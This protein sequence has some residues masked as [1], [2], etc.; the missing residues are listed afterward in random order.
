MVPTVLEC[1]GHRSR[2]PQL[3]GVTQS[4]IEGVSFAHSFDDATAPAR[5]HTQYFEMFAHRSI[6]HD[7]WRAVCPFP[8]TSFAEAGVSF[9]QLEL[10]ENK[11]RELDATGWELYNVQ[12]DPAE[13]NNLADRER[14][15]LIEMIALWYTEAGKYNVLPLDSR[16]TMRFADE[17]PQIASERDT[18]VYYPDTQA[19]PENVAAKVLNRAHTITVDAEV[20]AGDEGVLVCHGSNVGG[21]ILFVQDGRLH[22]V[23][24]YVGAEELRVSSDQPVPPG[25]HA[26]ALRVR[27]D[28]RPRS[29]HRQGRCRHGET[30]RRR[31][32]RRS[33]GVHGDCPAGVGSGQR[34]RGRPRIPVRR[35]RCCTLRRSRS[36]ARSP[37]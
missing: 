17:R 22:Y 18:Y 14:A 11:L 8:G 33:G 10:T 12:V 9:G 35:S 36:P 20:A 26:S 34:L 3:R 21:Y 29:E 2:R 30:V 1:T 5:H 7:G 37:R 15:K 32:T 4:P 31:G 25:K 6:Y 19:V 28:R 23:H 13:T 27:A 24:N 16:G